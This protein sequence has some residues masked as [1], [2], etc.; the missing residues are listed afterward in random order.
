MKGTL[1]LFIAL[2]LAAAA[3][4]GRPTQADPAPVP[5]T[6]SDLSSLDRDTQQKILL[7]NQILRVFGS[8]DLGAQWNPRDS[9]FTF[10]FQ[11][12]AIVSQPDSS[13]AALARRVAVYVREHYPGY[14]HV[15]AVNVRYTTSR[16]AF[17]M[18]DIESLRDSGG[19]AH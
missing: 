3:G 2:G 16:Y 7:Q 6:H 17:S 9:S 12:S 15:R 13:R 18:R 14:A 19:A 5:V 1:T 10:T 4:C 8:H 11:D